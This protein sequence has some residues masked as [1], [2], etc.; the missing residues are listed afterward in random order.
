MGS[1]QKYTEVNRYYLDDDFLESLGSIDRDTATKIADYID[2]TI[3]YTNFSDGTDTILGGII[4][5]NVEYP[6]TFQIEVYKNKKNEVTL[7]DINLISIDD[8]L[9]MYNMKLVLPPRGMY[10]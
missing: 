5:E 9:D 10:D 8:Y 4:D 1:K 6:I 2:D 3:W 7:S